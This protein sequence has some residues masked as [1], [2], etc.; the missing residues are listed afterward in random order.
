MYYTVH[1]KIQYSTCIRKLFLAYS[2]SSIPHS[3]SH[4]HY[5]SFIFPHP[6]FLVSKMCK[7]A[8]NLQTPT[9]FASILRQVGSC[10]NAPTFLVVRLRVQKVMNI[11]RTVLQ[12]LGKFKKVVFKKKCIDKNVATTK[13]KKTHFFSVHTAHANSLA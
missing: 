7:V 6:S 2:S 8:P 12:F 13:M 4:I 5:S 1:T 9:A 11:S 3:S 10:A